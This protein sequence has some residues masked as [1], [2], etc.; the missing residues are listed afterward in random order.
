MK[1]RAFVAGLMSGIA[2]AGPALAG[3][4]IDSIVRQLRKQG[5][6]SV[7][8]ERTLLGRVRIVA[9]RKDGSREIIVNPRT[10][11]ILRDLWTPLNGSASD[12]P[13]LNEPDKRGGKGGD[14]ADDDD[15]DDDDDDDDDDD[16]GSNS[17]SGSSGSGDGDD[18]DDD[19][20]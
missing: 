11:E 3:D 15:N 12:G 1:R 16:S 2:L 14:D 6:R 5:F 20:D 9:D 17:G 19:D 10:G 8:Q 7:V 4:V 18:G 13:V